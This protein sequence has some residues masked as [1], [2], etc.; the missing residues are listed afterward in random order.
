MIL[1]AWVLAPTSAYTENILD[2][3][4]LKHG[5]AFFHDL[6]YPLGFTH[7]DYVNPDAPKG[8]MLVLATQINFNTPALGISSSLRLAESSQYSNRLRNFDFDAVMRNQDILMPPIHELKATYHSEAALVPL[9]RNVAGVSHPVVDFLVT[10]ASEATTIE[11]MIASCRA[12]D[13]VLLWQYYLIPLYAVD[14]R[15]TVHWDKFGV[16]DFEPQYLPA[17]P[18]GWWYDPEKAARIVT[19]D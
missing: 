6:K 7:F 3:V 15:R 9:S 8:G 11:Q 2:N 16:P 10:K 5:V 13:R 4:E 19:I 14:L 18:D 1:L 17:F 12:L